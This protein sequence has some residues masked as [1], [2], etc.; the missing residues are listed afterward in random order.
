MISTFGLF[1]PLRE[2]ENVFTSSFLGQS[3][4]EDILYIPLFNEDLNHD[5]S[6]EYIV[7]ISMIFTEAWYL[8]RGRS[9]T[10]GNLGLGYILD[11]GAA[12]D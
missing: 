5:I 7:F 2:S 9:S 6:V 4:L 12:S 8:S 1:Y 3:A 10:L 11:L